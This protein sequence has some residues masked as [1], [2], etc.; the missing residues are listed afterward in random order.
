MRGEA[1]NP[2]PIRGRRRDTDSAVLDALRER[3]GVAHPRD[4]ARMTSLSPNAARLRLNRLASAGALIRDHGGAFALLD[5]GLDE[6]GQR[7][8]EALRPLDGDA[9]LTGLD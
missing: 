7:I 5:G 6:E 2:L 9:H 4:V 8:V 3:A 1:D